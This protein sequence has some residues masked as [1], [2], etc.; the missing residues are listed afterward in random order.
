VQVDVVVPAERLP[1]LMVDLGPGVRAA[2]TTRSGGVS[3]RPWD[4]L[5]LGLGVDDL[6]AC[7]LANRD[8]VERW[9]GVPVA[10]AAQVHGLDVRVLS[11]PPVRSATSVGRCDALVAT[12]SSVAIAVLA[13][14]C[15]P[16]LLAD[17]AACVVGV[18]HAGRRG[19]V[20]GVIQAAVATLVRSG[21]DPGRLR[22]VVGPAISG[23]AYEVPAAM[24]AEVAAVVPETWSTTAWG[25]PALDLPAGV[26][27]VLG[28]AGVT[29]VEVLDICTSTDERFYS[30]R[31]A[32]REGT[33]TG[34]FAGVVRLER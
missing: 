16:V 32:Q 4:S 6:P 22:A 33:S 5:N 25:T 2:F 13:A 34:R 7:V 10:Y 21:A 9:V 27:A 30:H 12:S 8:L 17:G 14:D 15:V 29:Q 11:G 23:P 19:L 31:R 1:V 26:V 3:A 18:A 28:R 24:R 20:L